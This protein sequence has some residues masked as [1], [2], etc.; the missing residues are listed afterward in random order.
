MAANAGASGAGLELHGGKSRG[1]ALRRSRVAGDLRIRDDGQD[2]QAQP[3]RHIRDNQASRQEI[4][5]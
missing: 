1:G 2:G 4:K 5:H 3:K